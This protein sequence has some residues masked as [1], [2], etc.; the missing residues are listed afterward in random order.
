MWHVQSYKDRN[1]CVL[2]DS[3]AALNNFQINSRLVWDFHQS[4]MEWAE[5]NGSTGIGAITR[6]K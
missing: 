3:Q 2:L 5:H 6:G 1:I 4:L